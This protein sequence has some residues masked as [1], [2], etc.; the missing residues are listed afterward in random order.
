VR[1]TKHRHKMPRE[2]V[3]PPFLEIFKSYSD[4]VL[5]NWLYVAVLDQGSWT[6]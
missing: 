3:E 5:G 1:V 6:R 4:T 2:V